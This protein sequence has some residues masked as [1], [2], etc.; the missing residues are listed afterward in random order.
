MASNTK[1]IS[2]FQG[3][4]STIC[5]MCVLLAIKAYMVRAFVKTLLLVIVFGLYHGL[6]L[7][8]IVLSLFIKDNSK[9][10]SE[11]TNNTQV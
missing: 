4:M 8:P 3:A 7:L 11:K 10:N 2:V 9:A 5:G 6:L 1:Y